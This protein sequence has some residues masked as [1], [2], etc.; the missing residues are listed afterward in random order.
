MTT[1]SI[2][3][4]PDKRQP[5]SNHTKP[6][7]TTLRLT[8]F[9]RS[10]AQIKLNTPT[11]KAIKRC[12][13][14]KGYYVGRLWACGRTA[15]CTGAKPVGRSSTLDH[16][17]GGSHRVTA[18]VRLYFVEWVPLASS[19]ALHQMFHCRFCRTLLFRKIHIIFTS[20]CF[21]RHRGFL[22]FFRKGSCD[23]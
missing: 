1:T 13:D 7:Q 20:N 8:D 22:R 9:P 14:S 21:V 11:A 3:R 23:I 18:H 4:T 15:S 19:R 17:L 5:T 6:T 10:A 12:G 16:A 2:S